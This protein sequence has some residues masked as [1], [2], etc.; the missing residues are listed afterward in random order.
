M[1]TFCSGIESHGIDNIFIKC[2]EKL[3]NKKSLSASSFWENGNFDFDL[4]N[5]WQNQ[6][7][8]EWPLHIRSMHHCG[9]WS[10]DVESQYTCYTR[11]TT[12]CILHRVCYAIVVFCSLTPATSA[13]SLRFRNV[14]SAAETVLVKRV[15]VRLFEYSS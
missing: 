7:S 8:M 5:G 12:W 14:H 13:L 4:R 1:A 6:S 9:N 11:I 2:A 10:C 3:Y 15:K